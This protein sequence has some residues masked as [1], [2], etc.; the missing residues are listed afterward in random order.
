MIAPSL[1]APSPSVEPIAADSAI[2]LRGVAKR[3]GATMALDVVDVDVS[4]GETVALL[5]RNGA[6]KSTAIAI[7]LGLA[8]PTLG[9]AITLGLEPRHA[10]QTGR[11]GAMLQAGGLPAGVRVGE[12]VD[13]VRRLYP[14]PLSRAAALTRAGLT[15]LADRQI[16]NLSGGE[17]QRVRFALAIAGDPD[18]VFLDEPTVAMDVQARR[19]FWDDM[20]RFAAEGRT[21][22]FATHYLEEADQVADRIIVLDRGRVVADGTG[23]SLKSA[24]AGRTVRFTTAAADKAHLAALRGVSQVEV[25]GDLVSLVSSDADATVRAL[26]TAGLPISNVEVTGAGLEEAF[27]ALTRREE[28]TS[29]PQPYQPDRGEPTS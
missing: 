6:G 11:I 27:L 24:V 9:R 22:L 18:L 8:D 2:S 13:F 25:R 21:I 10:V 1:A 29:D 26:L 20:R 14:Q 19:A 28:L 7:M 17:A 4:R 12:L 15:G 3:F 5:G 16:E 23:T